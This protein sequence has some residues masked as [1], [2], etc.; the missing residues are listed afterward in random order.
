MQQSS[1]RKNNG[2]E[3]GGFAGISHGLQNMAEVLQSIHSVRFFLFFH[4]TIDSPIRPMIMMIYLF[5]SKIHIN[6]GI[7]QI[8]YARKLHEVHSSL[9]TIAALFSMN[10]NTIIYNKSRPPSYFPCVGSTFNGHGWIFFSSLRYR[11]FLH[12]RQI[13]QIPENGQTILR[14]MVQCSSAAFY[15]CLYFIFLAAAM[16]S[17]PPKSACHQP[18]GRNVHNNRRFD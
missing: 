16:W 4:S 11:E 3:R 1:S 5:E 17:L 9:H 13:R 15:V 8:N 18:T 7:E 12:A 14:V 10:F 6:F 2:K